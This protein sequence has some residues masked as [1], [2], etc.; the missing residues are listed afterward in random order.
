MEAAKQIA[1]SA[2]PEGG[3]PMDVEHIVD[4]ICGRVA[5][6]DGLP[7][8]DVMVDFT[9][10]PDGARNA[11]MKKTPQD[12]EKTIIGPQVTKSLHRKHA[13]AA[14]LAVIQERQQLPTEPEPEPE[15]VP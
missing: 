2:V 6:K 9:V 7:D 1:R 15:I 4:L 13:R 5:Y 10:D 3:D 14:V 12:A 11:A 8:Y